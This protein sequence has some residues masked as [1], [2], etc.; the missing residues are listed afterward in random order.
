MI[1]IN[2]ALKIPTRLK[3]KATTTD[4]ASKNNNTSINRKQ[5]TS[6]ATTAAATTTITTPIHN[7]YRYNGNSSSSD[8]TSTR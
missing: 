6:A 2:V 1:M 3:N 8:K 7:D 5:P 4:N